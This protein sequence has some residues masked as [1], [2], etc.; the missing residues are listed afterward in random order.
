MDVRTIPEEEWADFF[1]RFSHDHVGWPVTIE[2][3]SGCSGVHTIA[4]RL[5]LQGIILDTKGSGSSAVEI[6]LGDRM[7][8]TFK[9]VVVMPRH[10]RQAEESSGNADLQIEPAN[11]PVTLVHVRDPVRSGR[12]RS[13]GRPGAG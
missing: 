4:S 6:A 12:R 5:P 2:V 13:A 3:P 10:V 8:P 9:H 1:P 7:K 11:G